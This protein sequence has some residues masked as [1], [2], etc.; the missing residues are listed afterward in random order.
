MGFYIRQSDQLAYE[1]VSKAAE[2][3][4][5]AA[6]ITMA[7][8]LIIGQGVAKDIPRGIAKLLIAANGEASNAQTKTCLLYATY[9]K[10]IPGACFWCLLAKKYPSRNGDNNKG[11]LQAWEKL[12]TQL[13]P[14]QIQAAQVKADQWQ[15][16]KWQPPEDL[17]EG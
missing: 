2:S 17:F 9:M 10:D 14:Q 4:Y 5:P 1:W 13:T 6:L 8:L 11:A 16:T 3:G 7:E 12:K 15:P